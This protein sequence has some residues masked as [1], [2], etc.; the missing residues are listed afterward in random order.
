MS[1]PLEAV[2]ARVGQNASRPKL[3]DFLNRIHQR[4]AY[5]KALE[6]GGVYDL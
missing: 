1:F 5:Q 3:M 4:P 2:T 6:R